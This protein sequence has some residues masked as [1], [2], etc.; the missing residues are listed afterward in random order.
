MTS[1]DKKCIAI[2]AAAKKG[3]TGDK[4]KHPLKA[5]HSQKW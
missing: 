5:S 3:P 2:T 1:G 4:K